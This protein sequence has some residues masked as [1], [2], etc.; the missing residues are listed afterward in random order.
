VTHLTTILPPSDEVP[1]ALAAIRLSVA[2]GNTTRPELVV[3]FALAAAATTELGR[4]ISPAM[5]G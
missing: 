2:E 3:T 4:K 5:K 1:A